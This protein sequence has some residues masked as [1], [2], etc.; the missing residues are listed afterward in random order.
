MDFAPPVDREAMYR[1]KMTQVFM[2]SQIEIVR[3]LAPTY[4]PMTGIAV[5]ASN[6]TFTG[7]TGKAHISG[8]SSAGTIMTGEAMTELSSIQVSIPWDSTP[9]PREEDQVIVLL[10]P[11]PS[12]VDEVLRIIDVNR[13][14]NGA[15][16][17]TLSCTF[18]TPGSYNQGS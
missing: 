11:N 7:Y 14:G 3:P 6:S 12:L 5:A 17:I 15:D 1:R 18:V 4:D 8:S 9:Y 13:G 16:V 10:D 2:R